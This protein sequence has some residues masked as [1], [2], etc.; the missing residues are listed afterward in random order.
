MLCGKK[1]VMSTL[2]VSSFRSLW[3]LCLLALLLFGGPRAWS[4]TQTTLYGPQTFDALTP[5][6]APGWASTLWQVIAGGLAGSANG[7]SPTASGAD[8]LN[9]VA[10]QSNMGGRM[11][12]KVNISSAPNYSLAALSLCSSVDGSVR[13]QLAPQVVLGSTMYG[14]VNG[15]GHFL[16]FRNGV[17]VASY[18]LAA[19]L[20]GG[21]TRNMQQGDAFWLDC[22]VNAGVISLKFWPSDAAEPSGYTT[23]YTDASP[24]GAGYFGLDTAAAGGGSSPAAI[25]I[26][27]LTV[28]ALG[29]PQNAP[30]PTNSADDAGL[31]YIGLHVRSGSGATSRAAAVNVGAGLQFSGAFST[32]SLIFDTSGQATLPDIEIQADNLALQRVAP[33]AFGAVAVTLDTTRATHRVRVVYDLYE[34]GTTPDL[35]GTGAGAVVF[36]GLQLSSGGTLYAAAVN[37]NSI[38]Y[39]GDSLLNT[40]HSLGTGSIL[41]ATYDVARG[42][43]YTVADLLGCLPVVNGHSA[44]GITQNF[45]GGAAQGDYPTAPASFGQ[46]RS[47]QSYT[48]APAVVVIGYGTNDNSQGISA[49]AFGVGA[50]SYLQQVRAARP[51]ALICWLIMPGLPYAPAVQTAMQQLGDAR[52]FV[53]DRSGFAV[54]RPDG[55]HFDLNSELPFG[56]SVAQ[57]LAAQMQAAGYKLQGA[58]G[59]IRTGLPSRKLPKGRN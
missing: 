31:Q 48:L 58:S 55:T 4:Q 46:I 11:L 50:K 13:Y 49:A 10:A 57:G 7:F 9:S 32:C 26:D 25:E 41:P 21:A 23:V 35:W 56:L 18:D 39:L 28:Y 36:S 29:T 53:L 19:N 1:R 12:Q 27:N 33:D 16:L 44:Q 17:Q 24:L 6:T 20:F 5:G 3:G 47:G 22:R 30:A 40:F 52:M 8:V 42:W 38:E 51:G 45:G 59:A 34:G 54:N 37:A 43:A 14:G 2:R 15:A